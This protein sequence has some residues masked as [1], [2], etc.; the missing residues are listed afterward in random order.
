V[1]RITFHACHKWD[2][3]THTQ[4][5]AANGRASMDAPSPVGRH[6]REEM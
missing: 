3:L 4:R 1:I 5:I 2:V 6:N